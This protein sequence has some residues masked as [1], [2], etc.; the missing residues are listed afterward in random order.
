MRNE[1]L[2]GEQFISCSDRWRR[3]SFEL[4]ADLRRR[5]PEA[6]VSLTGGGFYSLKA[7]VKSLHPADD[8]IVLLPSYLC[9]SII[10]AISAAGVRIGFYRITPELHVDLDHLRNVLTGKTR[11]LLAIEYFGFPFLPEELRFFRELETNGTPVVEDR[12]QSFFSHSPLTGSYA[13]NSFRKFLPVDG[14]AILSR[15]TLDVGPQSAYRTYQLLK[16]AGRL[17]RH[18]HY[19]TIFDT[20]GLALRLLRRAER[21]YYGYDNPSFSRR[22]LSILGRLD[23]VEHV[24][25]RRGNYRMLLEEFPRLALYKSLPETV[26]PLGFPI[27]VPERN[28]VRRALAERN[29]FCPVHWELPAAVRERPEFELSVRLSE[30]ILTIPL[31]RRIERGGTIHRALRDVLGSL[32]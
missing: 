8:E 28:A 22:D 15:R 23:L 2:G 20:E 32:A 14:S 21:S 7:I 5:Y 17:L 13:F 16:S 25:M 18:M 1:F 10:N 12:V 4:L 29:I 30:T 3:R 19:S 27:V 31:S 9:E 24:R 6:T 11:A 26:V